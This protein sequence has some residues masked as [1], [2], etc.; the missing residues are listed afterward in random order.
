MLAP[1]PSL[2]CEVPRFGFD[3]CLESSFLEEEN[4]FLAFINLIV[5]YLLEQ[6]DEGTCCVVVLHQG[7]EQLCP[8]VKTFQK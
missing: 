6:F 4:I 3:S 7:G 8:H 2:L 1:C 5:I